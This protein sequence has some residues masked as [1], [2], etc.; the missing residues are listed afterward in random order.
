MTTPIL[1][2]PQGARR[3]DPGGGLTRALALTRAR[4]LGLALMAGLAL[5]TGLAAPGCEA[6][7]EEHDLELL[8]RYRAKD[9][10]SCLF[11]M[12][13]TKDFCSRYT[14]QPPNLATYT[15]DWD[16]KRVK[17]QA[18]MYWGATARFVDAQ[19]G[20]VLE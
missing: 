20:C 19:F 3:R 17:T 15:I 8:T 16:R 1:A 7:Y 5:M 9:L 13:Q 18:M 11:V 6:T 14:R 4:A 10:C 2:P 12:E